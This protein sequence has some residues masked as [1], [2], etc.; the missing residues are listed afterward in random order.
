MSF[1]HKILYKKFPLYR[2]VVQFLRTIVLPGF[3]GVPMWYFLKFFNQQMANEVVTLRGSAVAFNFF[4]ALIPSFIFFFTLIPYFPIENLDQ[5]VMELLKGYM[6]DSAFITIESTVKDILNQRRTGLL[7][8]GF[9]FTI[10]FATNGFYSLLDAF[11]QEQGRPFV[12][13]WLTAFGLMLALAFLFLVGIV[14]YLVSEII[15]Y[16]V[17]NLEIFIYAPN[18]F[19]I[20][21][22]QILIVFGLIFLAVSILYFLGPSQRHR[23]PQLFSPG[24]IVASILMVLTSIGFAFYVENFSQY[25]KFYGSLGA[26]IVLMIW[27]YLNATVLIIGYEINES[28]KLA[29]RYREKYKRK[30]PKQISEKQSLPSQN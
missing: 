20:Q 22:F 13:K 10:Y 1:L 30:T 17:I 9:L 21:L 19:V 16:Q 23:R 2:W 3:Q 7:S 26:L 12:T 18:Y 8:L 6:P 27:L 14:V 11:N 29:K 15:L 25:N 4:L 5:Q 28:I 24:S